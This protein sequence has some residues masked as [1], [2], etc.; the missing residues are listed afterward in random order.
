LLAGAQPDV[1]DACEGET[2]IIFCP[3]AGGSAALCG[4]AFGG[5]ALGGGVGTL[6][7]GNG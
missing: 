5:A 7:T 4:T 6:T 3:L 1:P 2:Q